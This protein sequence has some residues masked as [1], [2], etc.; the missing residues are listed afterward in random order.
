MD[1]GTQFVVSSAEISYREPARLDDEL[2]AVASCREVGGA[3][4]LFDQ[5]VLRNSTV[6]AEGIV[7]IALID[8][9]GKPRRIGADLRSALTK[10]G[11]HKA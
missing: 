9:A 4:I 7:R 10:D 5:T 6:L 1:D 8:N 3:T 2:L 11:E